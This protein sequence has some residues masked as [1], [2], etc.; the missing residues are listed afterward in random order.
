MWFIGART[1]RVRRTVWMGATFAL[2]A[3]VC[4]SAFGTGRAVGAMTAAA[5][6][7][8][9]RRTIA[10]GRAFPSHTPSTIFRVATRAIKAA[11]WRRAMETL[12]G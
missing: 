5:C 12:V 1:G 3:I 7:A 2:W 6:F 4:R 10:A 9:S 11:T 8:F